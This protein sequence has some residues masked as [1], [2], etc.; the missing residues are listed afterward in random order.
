MDYYSVWLTAILY[1]FY[2]YYAPCKTFRTVV[3]NDHK[4]FNNHKHCLIH[5][6]CYFKLILSTLI[7]YVPCSSGS[8]CLFWPGFI[9]IF[10]LLCCVQ[11]NLHLSCYKAFHIGEMAG[12]KAALWLEIPRRCCLSFEPWLV[13]G[14]VNQRLECWLLS[15]NNGRRDCVREA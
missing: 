7:S 2:L 5:W 14:A 10:C 1:K 13:K 8:A 15:E 3:F 12:L 6:V 11:V 4:G 9:L